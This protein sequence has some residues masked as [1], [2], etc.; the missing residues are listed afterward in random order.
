[1]LLKLKKLMIKHDIFIFPVTD[2][3]ILEFTED[4]F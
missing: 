2:T 4:N 3:N 1:M